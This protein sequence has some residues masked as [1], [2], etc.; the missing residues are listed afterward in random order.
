MHE[1][2]FTGSVGPMFLLIWCPEAAGVSILLN[3]IHSHRNESKFD[4]KEP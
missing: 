1:I 4:H 2:C 3:S